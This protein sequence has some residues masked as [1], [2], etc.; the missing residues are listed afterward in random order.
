MGKG[1]GFSEC[2]IQFDFCDIFLIFEIVYEMHW[3]YKRLISPPLAASGL[4]GLRLGEERIKGK[5]DVIFGFHL[6]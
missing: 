1:T 2:R 3:F 6:T 4:Q 5:G